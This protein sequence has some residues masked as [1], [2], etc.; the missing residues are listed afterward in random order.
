MLFL[1]MGVL[2]L[3]EIIRQRR[4]SFLKY[5]LDQDANSILF[6]VF[7]K[8]CESRTKK[9]WVSTVIRDLEELGINVNFVDIQQTNKQKWKSITKQYI[10][11]YTF[12]KLKEKQ[13][14][15]SKVKDINY[16]RFEMQDYLAPSNEKINKKTSLLIFKLRSIMVKVKVN[17]N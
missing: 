12:T 3:R 4:L 6:Q 9:D 11:E 14:K 16:S 10:K 8:Q 7:E 13:Q 5:I 17:Y 15:H 2:P 1:E